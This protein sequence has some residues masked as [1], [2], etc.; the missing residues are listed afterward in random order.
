MAPFFMLA[1]VVLLTVGPLIAYVVA[2]RRRPPQLQ[3]AKLGPAR[4]PYFYLVESYIRS[5]QRAPDAHTRQLVREEIA[6][7]REQDAKA[8]PRAIRA[9]Y[10]V[11]VTY[12]I[13][14]V[15][16][17]VI[18]ITRPDARVPFPTLLWI[19]MGGGCLVAARRTQ[20]GDGSTEV[21]ERALAANRDANQKT[22]DETTP[23][24]AD[25]DRSS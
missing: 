12:L 6:W 13:G 16:G 25:G 11:G 8:G 5:G 14:G 3:A 9:L 2:N 1:L 18:E 23:T 17:L 22:H 10:G 7:R 24:E 15:T 21:W 4:G 19:I 20:R